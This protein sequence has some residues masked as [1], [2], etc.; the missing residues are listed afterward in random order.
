VVHIFSSQFYIDINSLLYWLIESVVVVV[1][2][3]VCDMVMIEN[4]DTWIFPT[5]Q[6]GPLGID[7]DSTVTS[8]ILENA[9]RES[10]LHITS[11]YFNFSEN[12]SNLILK[13][14][15][16]VKVI[17]ASPEVSSKHNPFVYVTE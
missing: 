7:H 10:I 2:V 3:V 16:Y 8:Y 5:L 17:V 12:Y 11:P 9:P 1:V 4:R 13:S 14:S 15:S 6:M